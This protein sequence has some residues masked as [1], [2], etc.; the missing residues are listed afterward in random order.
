MTHTSHYFEQISEIAAA[1]DHEGIERIATGLAELRERGGRLFV[2]G[3]GGSASNSSHAVSD[4]RK[5]TGIEA[6]APTDNVSEI[7]ARTND[8]GWPTI[9]EAWLQTSNARKEDAIL[10]LSVGGGDV[11]RNVSPNIVR[12]LDEAKSR[13]LSIFGIVGRDGGYTKKIGDEVVVVPTLDPAFITV[14]TESFQAAVWHCL[15]CHPK[16]MLSQ[17]KWENIASGGH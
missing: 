14:H 2:L 8:E 7:T 17:G 16:L 6:Y 13:G 1:I 10:V 11:E 15:V 12:G 9:F 4:F 3:V 5:L